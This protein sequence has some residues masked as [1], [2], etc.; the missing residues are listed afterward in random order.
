MGAAIR[1]LIVTA[2]GAVAGMIAGCVGGSIGHLIPRPADYPF[3]AE[4]MPLPHHVPK[5]P[6]GVSFRFAMVHDVIHERFPKHGP[7]FYR[8]RERLTRGKRETL[9]L[10]DPAGFPL[11]DDLGAGLER[12]GR[13]GEAV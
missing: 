13:S 8:E 10:D 5:Y 11:M 6:G 7:A 4:R 12:L 9:Q 3:L 2:I 1:R